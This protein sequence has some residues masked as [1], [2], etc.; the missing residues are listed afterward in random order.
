MK[1]KVDEGNTL[2]KVK[3][4]GNLNQYRKVFWVIN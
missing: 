3:S 2:I 1:L 4:Y